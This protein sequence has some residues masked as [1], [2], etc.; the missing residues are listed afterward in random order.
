LLPKEVSS[1]IIENS[2]KILYKRKPGIKLN[3]KI[4]HSRKTH[5]R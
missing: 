1:V 5:E 3:A 2:I 4:T